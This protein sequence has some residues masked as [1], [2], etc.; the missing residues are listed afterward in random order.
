MEIDTM[1]IQY[2]GNRYLV[3]F[4]SEKYNLIYNRIEYFIRVKNGIKYF[5]KLC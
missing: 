1:E 4:S 2:S 5:S 3:L